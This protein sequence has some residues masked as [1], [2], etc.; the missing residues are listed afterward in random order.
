MA[1]LFVG[2][3]RQHAGWVL[4]HSASTGKHHVLYDDGEVS[5]L[6]HCS[7][8]SDSPVFAITMPISLL[9]LQTPSPVL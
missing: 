7:P 6:S 8:V 3:G 5:L 4:A 9:R 1:V 2:D